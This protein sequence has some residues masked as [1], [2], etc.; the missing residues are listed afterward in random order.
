MEE[1]KEHPALKSL[2]PKIKNESER[3]LKKNYFIMKLLNDIGCYLDKEFNTL[4]EFDMEAHFETLIE[5]SNHFQILCEEKI[6]KRIPLHLIFILI[7]QIDDLDQHFENLIK[8]IM[9]IFLSDNY[10]KIQKS[11]LDTIMN[12]ELKYCLK[13]ERFSFVLN[14]SKKFVG[15]ILILFDILCYC[16]N[17]EEN[18]YYLLKYVLQDLKEKYSKVII[19][20]SLLD[21][22]KTN[23]ENYFNLLNQLLELNYEEIYSTQVLIYKDSKFQMREPSNE[24]LDSYYKSDF[25]SK[26]DKKKKKKKKKKK[27]N[28]LLT[29]NPFE[30]SEQKKEF[31]IV[32]DKDSSKISPNNQVTK[33][34]ISKDIDIS[35]MSQMEKYLYNN[36]NEVKNELATTKNE[37]ATTK[38][39]LGTTINKL[40]TTNNKLEN[41][42]KKYSDLKMSV[43]SLKLELKKIKIRSIYKGVIDIFCHIYNINLNNNYYNKLNDLLY[44]LENYTENNKIK[45]LKQFLIDI[46]YYLQ[47]GNVLAHSIEDNLTPIEM[48][49]PLIEKD[50]KKKY[51]NT[52]AILQKLSLNKPLS[53]ALINYYS[54]KDKKKLIENINFSL[55]ELEQELL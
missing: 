25:D 43:D 1:R 44:V 5:L 24:E 11:I 13:K 46:Y 28:N 26:D 9:Q 2:E 35:Q 33:D 19:L 53:Q 34:T 45:E 14:Y 21:S 7:V 30:Q 3:L 37:L 10:C 31:N 40:V 12:N 54:L 29:K 20:D 47:K 18:D 41:M 16:F 22:I 15:D 55:K 32:I 48:I 8:Y 50:S 27:N 39:E 38:N 36:L 23:K 42:E 51:L 17:E 4:K 52:K 6:E 49:F